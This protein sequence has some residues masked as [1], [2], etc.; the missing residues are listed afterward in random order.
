MEDS[1]IE[2]ALAAAC[3]GRTS[4]AEL[5]GSRLREVLLG[6]LGTGAARELDRLA[7][8]HVQLPSG[9]RLLVEYT[10]GQPPAIRSRLQDFFGMSKGPAVAGG[11]LPLVLHLLAPSGRALQVTSDLSGFWERHYPAV[12]RE[13]MRKYPRHPWPEDGRTAT[14]PVPRR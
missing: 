7:P 5:E 3:A 8:E 13:L 12:R 6:L 4:L 9:R 1:D 2:A 10:L 14:P 11:R